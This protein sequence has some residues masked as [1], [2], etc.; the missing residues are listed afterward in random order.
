MRINSTNLEL[1]PQYVK[2]V[3]IWSFSGPFFPAFGRKKFPIWT[4]FTQYRSVYFQRKR[5]FTGFW[6]GFKYT[7]LYLLASSLWWNSQTVAIKVTIGVVAS[8]VLI[9]LI[10]LI[11]YCCL[12][13]QSSEG[14][15]VEDKQPVV[16]EKGAVEEKQPVD[17]DS[18]KS[19]LPE[20]TENQFKYTLHVDDVA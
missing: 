4:L 19:K 17:V 7:F 15:L 2:S 14:Q 13:H 5:G 10:M 11:F 8:L 9:I 12:P 16:E 6:Q 20:L 3:R 1:H 18:K